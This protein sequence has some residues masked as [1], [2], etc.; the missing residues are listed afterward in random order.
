MHNEVCGRLDNAA[1]ETSAAAARRRACGGV[2][3]DPRG[4]DG[5]R[6]HSPGSRG[7]GG[8]RPAGARS[9]GCLHGGPGCHGIGVGGAHAASTGRGR[10]VGGRD[11]TA[12]PRVGWVVVVV[13][14]PSRRGARSGAALG[15]RIGPRGDALARQAGRSWALR[16]VWLL[17]GTGGL[18]HLAG[19][20]PFADRFLP[21]RL[22]RHHTVRRGRAEHA[23]HRRDHGGVHRRGGAGGR[24]G[25]VANSTATARS[26]PWPGLPR[27]WRCWR[28]WRSQHRSAGATPSP[29]W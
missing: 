20:N 24:T 16:A 7:V 5:G 12:A 26:R 29:M 6:V 25:G 2:V 9:G 10:V 11:R 14:W 1:V 21:P 28:A 17:A 27:H 23:L 22:R 3:D 15:R 19:Y 4:R 8:A 13:G 18:V